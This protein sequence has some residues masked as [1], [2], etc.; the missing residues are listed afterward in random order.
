MSLIEAQVDRI[1]GPTHHFG[2][3]GVGNVASQ[4]SEGH[5]SS[6]AAAAHQGLDKMRAV[7]ALGVP[8]FVLP[9]H[10]RPDFRFLRSIGFAGTDSDVL[11]RSADEAPRL[12]SAAMSCSAMWT[13]NAATVSPTIDNGA[14]VLTLSVANLFSSVH[15]AGEPLYTLADLR[16]CFPRARVVPA[17]PGGAALRDEGAANHMRLG[18]AENKPGIH[19]FVYGDQVPL[20]EKYWPRQSLECCQAIARIHQL[21]LENTFFLKQ[22][23]AAIDAGAFHNDVVAASHHGLLISH[24]SAFFDADIT[25]SAIGDRYQR[26]FGKPLTTIIVQESELSLRRAIGTYLFN[27]QLISP[28]ELTPPF[29]ICPAQVRDDQDARS[30]VQRW[31][32]RGVLAGCQFAE[33]RQSMS[34]GGGP[35]CLRLR[36]PMTEQEFDQTSARYR[37]TERLDEG[38][39]KVVDEY[40]PNAVTLAD[41]SD[42]DFVRQADEAKDLVQRQFEDGAHN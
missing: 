32:D 10:P 18:S 27:S 16:S 6:P 31:Q 24:E 28:P 4:Q 11:Q 34:G 20:P 40:Y 35:A 23:P 17:L 33:L 29:M 9:P 37:W 2:G 12:L 39:C 41:L 42:I 19:I 15:R 1:V 8:Q 13:A 21:P 26:L 38:L 30:L 25:L 5:A 14:G 7:A 22:N 36:V 3:L